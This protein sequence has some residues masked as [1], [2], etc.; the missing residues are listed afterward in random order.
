MTDSTY[1]DQKDCCQFLSEKNLCRLH[2]EGVK[3]SECFWWP[4]HIYGTEPENLELRV[5]TICCKAGYT[6]TPIHLCLRTL[7][8]EFTNSE[9]MYFVGSEEFS[10]EILLKNDSYLSC[11]CQLKHLICTLKPITKAFA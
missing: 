9:L 4:V 5:A 1:T 8:K 7:Q 10:A 3:S 6:L 11:S 2:L